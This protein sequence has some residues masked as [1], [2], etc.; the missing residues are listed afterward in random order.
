MQRKERQRWQRWN[1]TLNALLLVALCLV[2]ARVAWGLDTQDI[3][4][5]WTPEGEMFA[6]QR[7]AGVQGSDSRL[8]SVHQ[9]YE[10]RVILP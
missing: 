10:F 8:M 9:F 7:A 4:F 3:M 2:A 1:R 6:M 5:E